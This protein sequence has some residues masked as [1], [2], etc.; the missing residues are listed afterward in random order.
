MLAGRDN[1]TIRE[2][3]DDYDFIMKTLVKIELAR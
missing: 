2:D 3:S 1:G